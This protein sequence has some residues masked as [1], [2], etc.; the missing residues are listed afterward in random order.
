MSLYR[1]KTQRN[2]RRWN[3][4]PR[5]VAQPIKPKHP[6][7]ALGKVESHGRGVQLR[8]GI[9]K[10]RPKG[11]KK[12]HHPGADHVASL[13]ARR[14]WPLRSADDPDVLAQRGHVPHR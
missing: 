2:R 1:G 4:E 13:V 6:A 14:L 7:A 10:A 8:W 12:R 9:Q 3:A 11:G 5:L